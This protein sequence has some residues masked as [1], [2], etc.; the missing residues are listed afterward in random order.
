M[1]TTTSGWFTSTDGKIS[2]RVNYT[3]EEAYRRIYSINSIAAYSGSGITGCWINSISYHSDTVASVD[4]G[5]NSTN[6]YNP[7]SA[8]VYISI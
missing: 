5:Y 2:I 3:W 4:V 6:G 8:V 1:V 7:K